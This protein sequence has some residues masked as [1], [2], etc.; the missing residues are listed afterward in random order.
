[1]MDQ[2]RRQP[3]NAQ[4]VMGANICE[5][6]TDKLRITIIASKYG[7]PEQARGAVPDPDIAVEEAAASGR[8]ETQFFKAAE[9]AR[10]RSR[11]APPAPDLSNDKKD[12]IFAAQNG[13]AGRV[14]KA[15]ARL[16]QTQLPL[17]I[18]S[19]DRFE[20]AQPTIHR[21]EDL[22]VPTYIR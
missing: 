3:G 20:K 14:R 17:E 19:K 7:R 16:L 6:L 2:L 12:R 5:E 8:I 15:A 21:G 11:F 18:I 4:L 22:D 9:V 13:R 10:T 1:V